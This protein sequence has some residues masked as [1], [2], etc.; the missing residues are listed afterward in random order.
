MIG[1]NIFYIVKY[2]VRSDTGKIISRCAKGIC[3]GKPALQKCVKELV[4]CWTD[5]NTTKMAGKV[6]RNL[7]I[8]MALAGVVVGVGV[9]NGG[10]DHPL[11]KSISLLA[12]IGHL[13][14]CLWC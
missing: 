7:L 9:R 1:T 13:W 10:I 6:C 4:K 14:P 8:C 2:A 11:S 3:L 12:G 5:R